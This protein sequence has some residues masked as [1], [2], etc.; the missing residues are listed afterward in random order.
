MNPYATP[1]D[2][3]AWCGE[4]VVDAQRLLQASAIAVDACLIGAVYETDEHGHPADEAIAEVLRDAT[5][6]QASW[7]NDTGGSSG[8]SQLGSLR[9][10]AGES[11]GGS[12]GISDSVPLML[13]IAGLIPRAPGVL[14]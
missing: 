3:E 10:D 13:Q 6:A 12:Q 11:D 1:D 8:P 7:I 9:F 2:L 5:C 14:R 4:P